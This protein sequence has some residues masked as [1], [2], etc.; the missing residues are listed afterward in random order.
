[1]GENVGKMLEGLQVGILDGLRLVGG[2]VGGLAV[3]GF[4]DGS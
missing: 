2:E 3:D 4:I 1:M